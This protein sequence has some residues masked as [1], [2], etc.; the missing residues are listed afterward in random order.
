MGPF[1]LVAQTTRLLSQVLRHIS[2]TSTLDEEDAILLDRALRALAQVVDV[3]G[4]LQ[5]LHMMNQQTSCSA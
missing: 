3:E 2:S 4:Q 5:N 1:A